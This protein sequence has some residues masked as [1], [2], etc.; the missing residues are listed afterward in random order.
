MD[1]TMLHDMRYEIIYVIRRNLQVHCCIEGN[2][3][4]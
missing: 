4:V 1:G 3:N 2:F